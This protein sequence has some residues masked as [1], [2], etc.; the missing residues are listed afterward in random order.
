MSAWA[1]S[2]HLRVSCQLTRQQKTF[3]LICPNNSKVFVNSLTFYKASYQTIIP[4]YFY[5]LQLQSTYIIQN[6]EVMD[7]VDQALYIYR[8]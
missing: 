2:G 6:R 8:V 1:R 4:L 5:N 3:T 7:V